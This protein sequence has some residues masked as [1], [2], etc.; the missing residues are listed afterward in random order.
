MD[1]EGLPI[2][3]GPQDLFSNLNKICDVTI[4]AYHLKG[5]IAYRIGM[6]LLDVL[7]YYLKQ[8]HSALKG[9]LTYVVG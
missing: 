7:T 9:K 5:Q 2:T 4:D 3:F 8:R 1:G 6:M